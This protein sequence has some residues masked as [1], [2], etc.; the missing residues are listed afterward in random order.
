MKELLKIRCFLTYL[1]IAF[2]NA[3][4]DLAH[5]ITI[6]NVL[7]KSF[8]GDTLVVLTALVNAMIL[9]P[10]I[11]LFSPAGFINDKYSHNKV[12][13]YAAVVGVFISFAIFLSYLAGA[14]E[15]A[16]I[17]T[18]ILSAQSAVYSPAKYGI[19]KSIVGTE[20]LGAA[21]GMIQA[22]T[23]VAILF[24]SFAFSYIFE[25]IYVAS[26]NPS[27]ILSSIYFIGFLIV[28]FSALEVI[29]SFKLPF[30]SAAESE[31]KTQFSAKKYRV[32]YFLGCFSSYCSGI[33][34]TL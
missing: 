14:F 11:F 21:N 16:F 33:P 27:D 18:L 29:F 5:K 23:I 25:V 1:S 12:I 28:I 19:I 6:Q 8:D 2:L 22:L 34:C 9:L 26:D 13:R 17:L 15:I 20:H 30:F 3:S 32:K 31:E 7:L 24:S 10:F 4:V